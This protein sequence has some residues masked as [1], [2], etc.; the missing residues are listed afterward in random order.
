MSGIP[1]L[2]FKVLAA[3]PNSLSSFKSL[4]EIIWTILDSE[5]TSAGSGLIH[6]S[7][8]MGNHRLLS[9]YGIYIQLCICLQWFRTNEVYIKSI[10]LW[11][12]SLS[13]FRK[14][15]EKQPFSLCKGV[16]VSVSFLAYSDET[17]THLISKRPFFLSDN[18]IVLPHG[19]CKWG[20]NLDKIKHF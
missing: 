20:F 5:Q 4:M 16:P 7:I 18:W 13:W 3:L 17:L 14:Q 6:P 10:N 8:L 1:A 19:F 12:E 9:L 11:I 2:S 15:V